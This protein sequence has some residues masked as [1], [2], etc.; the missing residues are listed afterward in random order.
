MF[1][2]ELYLILGDMIEK[3]EG[4]LQ[5]YAGPPL[6]G[7]EPYIVEGLIGFQPYDNKNLGVILA[8]IKMAEKG[9]Y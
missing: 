3:G 8:P 5:V 9:G 2:A 4:L 1:V 6:K 7:N